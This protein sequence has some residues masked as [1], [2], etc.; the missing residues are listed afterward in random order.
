MKHF[1]SIILCLEKRFTKVKIFFRCV[2]DVSHEKHA[3]RDV[4]ALRMLTAKM[5]SLNIIQYLRSTF[6]VC[7]SKRRSKISARARV[8]VA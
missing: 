6:P 8:C 1:I 5:I 2:V 7:R 4:R 3:L